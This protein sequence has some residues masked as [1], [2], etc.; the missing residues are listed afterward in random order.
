M[1]PTVLNPPA[2]FA[3]QR[4]NDRY[5]C[6]DLSGYDALILDV[7]RSDG[8]RYTLVLKDVE[9]EKRPDGR[10]K[11]TVSWEHDFHCPRWVAHPFVIRTT[12][13]ADEIVCG[14]SPDGSGRVV[15]HFK[16][17]K[18]FY[19]GKE[20]ENATPLDRSKIKRIGIMIRR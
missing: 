7:P 18:P 10:D 12:W 13:V 1:D 19:R 16:N 8:K 3:S 14:S 9:P 15:L 6:P 5:T 11:A 4:T 2:A 17:F 20:V